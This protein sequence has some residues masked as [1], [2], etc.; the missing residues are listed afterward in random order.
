MVSI[1]RDEG[2]VPNV[3]PRVPVAEPRGGRTSI[4]LRCGRL[5]VAPPAPGHAE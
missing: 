1:E 2:I 3:E 5:R 4:S